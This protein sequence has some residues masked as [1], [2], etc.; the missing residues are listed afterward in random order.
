MLNPAIRRK[1]LLPYPVITAA[2]HG[3]PIAVNMVVHHYSGYI[4]TLATRTSYDVHGNS[5]SQV[6]EE[7]RRRLETKLILSILSFDLN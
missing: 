4:A 2:V 5:I 6:D 3:E 1:E 7:L